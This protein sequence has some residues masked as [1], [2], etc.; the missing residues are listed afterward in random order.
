MIILYF[1]KAVCSIAAASLVPA[2]IVG[3]GFVQQHNGG[4]GLQLVT[5][6]E[7]LYTYACNACGIYKKKQYGDD[8]LHLSV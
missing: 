1:E 3:I 5:T 8:L 7:G 6:I 4:Y 2:L